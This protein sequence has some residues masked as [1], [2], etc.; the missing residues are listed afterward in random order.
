MLASRLPASADKASCC[1]AK[2]WPKPD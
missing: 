1:S 2:C